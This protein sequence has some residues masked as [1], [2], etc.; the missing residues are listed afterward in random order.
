LLDIRF[1]TVRSAFEFEDSYKIVRAF[2][3]VPEMV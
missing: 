1:Q 3:A 2:G